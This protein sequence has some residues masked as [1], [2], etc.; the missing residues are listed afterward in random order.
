MTRR[1]VL[2]GTETEIR[3]ERLDGALDELGY[4]SAIVATALNGTFIP[5]ASRAET[6]LSDGDQLEVVAPLQG[7]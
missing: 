4:A 5:R 1:I 2:N 3:A 6:V 7:G